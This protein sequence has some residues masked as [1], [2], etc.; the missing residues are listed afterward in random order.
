M[1]MRARDWGL[2]VLL[3]LLWGGSFFFSAVAVREIP[4]LT[5]VALRTGIAALVLMPFALG[6]GPGAFSPGGVL[7]AFAIMGLLNNLVP[8]SLIF[9]AQT[10]IPSG[11]ASILNATTPLFSIL[12]AHVALDDERLA[13]G[14]LAG[15]L[16]GIAGVAALFGGTPLA[17]ADLAGLGM[18]AC[19]GA[20]LSYGCASVFGRRFGR[21]GLA[22]PQVAFGQLFAT[23]LMIAPFAWALD[24]PLALPLPSAAATGAVLMLGIAST[25]VAY[26]VYFR[27]LASAGAVNTVLVTLLV[28]VSAILL[29]WA[30]LDEALLPRHFAGMALIGLGLLA[31]DGRATRRLAALRPSAGGRSSPGGAPPPSRRA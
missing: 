3:S 17:A 11:L 30:F 24:R 8:F 23:T 1:R 2:L 18:L 12:V 28:P 10:Q 25:A 9:W 31:I 7:A 5:T 4:P 21:M 15:I 16:F 20:A 27:L 13:P 14:K 26:V 29:G 19:L 22:A 6:R